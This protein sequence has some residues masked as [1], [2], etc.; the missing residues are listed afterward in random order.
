[1]PD[2]T[3]RLQ[4]RL[5]ELR[6]HFTRELPQRLQTLSEAHAALATQADAATLAALRHQAHR[7][8]GAA[9]TFGYSPLSQAA[10]ALEAICVARVADGDGDVEPLAGERR[11]EIA[12][13]MAA[14]LAAITADPDP[15]RPSVTAREPDHAG[16]LIYVVDDDTVFADQLAAQIG[17]FGYRVRTFDDPAALP[18]ASDGRP[19]AAL[20]DLMYPNGLTGP[21]ALPDG[22][23]PGG[24]TAAA[25]SVRN[26]LEARL[27]A[28]RAGFRAY[29]TKPLDVGAVV[30]FLDSATGHAPAEPFRILIVDDDATLAASH[31]ATL[32]DAGMSVVVATDAAQAL[33]ALAEVSPDLL[34][35]DM[36]LPTCTGRELALVVRQFPEYV[37]VPIVFLSVE[38]DLER[39]FATLGEIG[40]EFLTKPIEPTHLIQIISQRVRRARLLRGLMTRDSLTGLYNHT[41]I[42]EQL[43]RELLRV[44]RS[45]GRLAVAMVDIDHFKSINDR[46]GHPVGDRVIK[47]LARLMM[48]KLR[49]TDLVGRYGGEE[50]LAVLLDADAD[51]AVR[52]MDDLREQFEGLRHGGATGP[53]QVTLSCGVVTGGPDAAPQSLLDAADRALYQA[54][55]AGRNRVVL[56]SGGAA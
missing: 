3:D 54:K 51:A 41:R 30:A 21:A 29:F 37:G 22:G 34:L 20:L 35:L 7:L 36:Y 28:V 53:F 39:Q 19:A 47:S 46:H 15:A 13:A 11:V 8:A 49:K 6:Q 26:D 18:A 48:Q 38:R 10:S 14:V 45:G 23:M 17:A 40:D 32:E 24:L 42:K 27:A 56:A 4:A 55:H 31:A 25:I 50:F 12:R 5:A 44:R 33:A 16:P 9:G 2:A 1:M 52:L 43:D